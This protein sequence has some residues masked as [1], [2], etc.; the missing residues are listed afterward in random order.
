MFGQNSPFA[1]RCLCI[2]GAWSAVAVF[3]IQGVLQG[4]EDVAESNVK[5]PIDTTP[6]VDSPITDADRTHWSFAPVK[7]SALPAVKGSQWLQTA[8]DNFALAKLE[9][10]GVVPAPPAARP[11]ILRRLCFDLIGLPPTPQELM[12][13]ENDA[14]PD[15]YERLVDRLLAAPGLGERWGQYWLDLARFAETDGYEHDKVRSDAW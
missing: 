3:P 8:V 2:V 9:A 14:S 10:K 4:Q 6:I 12:A 11:T 15:A 5:T 7:R 13:F 1:L